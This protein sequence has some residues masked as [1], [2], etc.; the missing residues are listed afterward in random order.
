MYPLQQSLAGAT[1]LQVANALGYLLLVAAGAGLLWYLRTFAKRLL[2]EPYRGRWRYLAVGVGA[3]VVYGAAGLAEL[4]G[5]TGAEPFRRGATLFVFLFAAVGMRGIHR[6][7]GGGSLVDDGVARWL[8]PAVVAAFI[9]AWW[10]AYLFAE[11]AVGAG[12][13]LVGLLVA[14]VYAVYRAVGV[15]AA[16]EGTSVAAVTRQFLPALLALA[17]V[18]A[19]E[20]VS[21]FAPD[22][23][24]V[25]D[26]VALV[27]TVLAGAFLFTTAVAIRQQGGEIERMYDPTTWREEETLTE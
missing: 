23:A 1:T 22:A 17:L 3:A 2:A 20:H 15:V 24:A 14:V 27:G 6:S 4:L 9:L 7:V 21:V 10:A 13:E 18:A 26:G 16:E 8:G 12:L 5:A 11:P 25:G 19:A